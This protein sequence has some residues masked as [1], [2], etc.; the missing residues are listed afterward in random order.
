LVDFLDCDGLVDLDGFAG[1]DGFESLT[2]VFV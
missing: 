1:F 2:I